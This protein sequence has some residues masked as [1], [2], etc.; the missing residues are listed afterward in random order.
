MRRVRGEETKGKEN[1]DGGNSI[2]T[3]KRDFALMNMN[4]FQFLLFHLYYYF[5]RSVHVDI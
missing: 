3:D 1:A 4:Q 5:S 2:R